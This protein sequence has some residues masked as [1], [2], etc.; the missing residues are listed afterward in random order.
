MYVQDYDEA[1]PAYYVGN[2]YAH[3]L[4]DPY[5]KNTQIWKCPSGGHTGGSGIGYGYNCYYL[6]F[7]RTDL[8][9]NAEMLGDITYPSECFVFAEGKGWAYS[10]PPGVEDDRMSFDRHNEGANYSFADGHA[11]W[12]GK[13]TVYCKKW[14]AVPDWYLAVR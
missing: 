3:Q 9:A 7:W 14:P 2:Y 1:I 6:G 4:L 10:E 8:P 11:K 13:S 5:I 12:L